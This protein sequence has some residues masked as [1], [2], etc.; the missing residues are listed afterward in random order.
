MDSICHEG[1]IE[2]VDD[3]SVYVKI[4]SASA[5]S[6]CQIKGACN[7]AESRDKI[8]EVNRAV[9]EAYSVGEKVDLVMEQ[10]SGTRAVILAYLI[11]FV[12]VLLSLVILLSAGVKEGISAL[13]SIF[14][15]IPYYLLLYSFRD[16]LKKKFSTTIRIR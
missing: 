3:Q 13:L 2:K 9:G 5:C 12:L 10:S 11:P 7:L 1:T 16:K 8:V 6:S 14:L 15:L 4:Q